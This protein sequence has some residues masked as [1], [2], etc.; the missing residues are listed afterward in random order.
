MNE[1]TR[2]ETTVSKDRRGH[3]RKPLQLPV[4]VRNDQG[5]SQGVSRDLSSSG[6]FLYCDS[7]LELGSKLEL[8]IMLPADF[9]VGPGG[10]SLCEASVVRV[11]K[12]E[13]KGVGFAA[14]FDRVAWVPEIT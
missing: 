6:I 8:V 13:G 10:W 2:S 7:K 1:G 4:T 5:E 9:G 3:Q 12:S 11:E 14:K